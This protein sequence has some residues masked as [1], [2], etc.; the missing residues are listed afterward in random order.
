MSEVEDF[1]AHYGVKGMR[2][3]VRKEA[4]AEVSS[5]RRLSLKDPKVRKAAI[6]GASITAIA[7]G[8]F[9]ASRLTDT[10]MDPKIV[11]SGAA[12][13]K[14]LLTQPTDMIYLSKAYKGAGVTRFGAEKTTLSFISKGGTKDFFEIFDRAGL[15]SSEFGSNNFKKLTNGD[16][17]FVFEDVLGRVDRAG[18]KIPHAVFVP[19][20]KASG[21]N[22]L[23]EAI[24]KFGPEI[25]ARYQKYLAEARSRSN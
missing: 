5:R 11:A 15:N 4:D 24:T 3:G 2:W 8:A 20:S 9:V 18:R 7:V 1:L 22:S 17:A 23:E 13:V 19:A 14:E 21:V 25:E 12:K 10:K 6:I 16:L